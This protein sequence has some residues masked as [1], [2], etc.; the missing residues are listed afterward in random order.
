MTDCHSLTVCL[1]H[2]VTRATPLTALRSANSQ[3]DVIPSAARPAAL[4][5]WND[6]STEA[7]PEISISIHSSLADVEDEWRRFERIADCDA[8]PD[9]RMA[10]GV[11]SS[12]RNSRRRGAGRRCRA[13]R[14]RP[15]WRNRIHPAA[16]H[17]SAAFDTA[18]ALARPGSVRLQRAAIVARF[19]ASAFRRAAFLHCGGS[20]THEM[21]ADRAVAPRLGRIREDAGDDRRP[22]QSVHLPRPDAQR[23][24]R[25]YHAFGRR[26]GNVLS[27]QALVGDAPA[28]PRQAQAHVPIRRH[29]LCDRRRR[30]RCQEDARNIDAAEELVIRAQGHSRHVRAAGLPGI[31]SRCRVQSGDAASGPCQPHRDRRRPARRRISRS[32]SAIAT[33]TSCRA[34]ATDGSRIMGRVRC[35][36]AN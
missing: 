10:R 32:C 35:I 14:L 19:R 24:Q 17:R 36:F 18:A 21:Q 1:V 5:R 28:R 9:L 11:A 26:L 16:R 33:I 4:P 25:A 23:Q 30:G 15:A 22:D 27:R 29:P 8:V 31:L 12:Y 7:A 20:C 6:V 2:A 3:A 34:I 13:F